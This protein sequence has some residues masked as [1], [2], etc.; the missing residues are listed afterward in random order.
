MRRKLKSVPWLIHIVRPALLPISAMLLAGQPASSVPPDPPIEMATVTVT[1]TLELPKPEAWEYARIGRVEVLTQASSAKSKRLVDHFQKFRQALAIIQLAP[2]APPDAD[3][4]LILCDDEARFGAFNPDGK[5]D[6]NVVSHLFQD[7]ERAA[8]VANVGLKTL[9]TEDI[10]LRRPT[11]GTYEEL[12][13]EHTRVID[14]EYTRYLLSFGR[15]R[16]PPPWLIEG[17]AQMAMDMELTS[18]TIKYGL[19]DISRGMPESNETEAEIDADNM[20]I[21][22][23]GSSSE[24]TENAAAAVGD[25]P[26]PL[27]LQRQPLIPLEQFFAVSADAPEALHP[28]VNSRWA[29]Q[30]YALVHFCQ[31]KRDG[32]LKDALTRFDERLATEPLSESLFQECFGLSYAQTL[33]QLKRYLNNPRHVFRHIKLARGH[34]LVAEDIEFRAATQGEIARIQGDAL[35]LANRPAAALQ[36]YR[37]AYARGERDTALLA[38]LGV[39]ELDAGQTRRAQTLLETATQQATARSSA[40][41]ALARLR[42]E[43]AIAQPAASG[44][45]DAT[46][47]AAVLAPLLEARARQPVGVETYQLMAKAWSNSAIEPSPANIHLLGEGV[48]RFPFDAK[49]TRDTAAL[50]L[51]AGD[52]PNAVAVAEMGLRFSSDESTR[53]SLR[54]L[55]SQAGSSGPEY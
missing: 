49:L 35:R 11:G 54:S 16:P 1:T 29:K 48:M 30:A 55:I 20:I 51:R 5:T 44:R 9:R 34:E 8:I 36:T 53:R 31:F 2:G 45:L 23:T 39:A 14:R 26:F 47:L 24:T 27:V 25:R 19:V 18:K 3:L 4:A 41:N 37:I 52:A 10:A 13:I 46:Q 42:L 15:E 6:Y 12:R 33:D 7:S 22:M 32:K 21:A 28:L 43:A 17:V 40:W 50:Y 38:A